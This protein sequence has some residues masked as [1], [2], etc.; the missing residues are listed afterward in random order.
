MLAA[1]CLSQ[2]LHSTGYATISFGC[3]LFNLKPKTTH[4]KNTYFR[5][6]V[7]S[8]DLNKCWT[9]SFFANEESK[10]K[11]TMQQILCE[12]SFFQWNLFC[13]VVLLKN[14]RMFPHL[15][16]CTHCHS[17][18]WKMELGNFPMF[19]SFYFSYNQKCVRT[20]HEF[21]RQ[22]SQLRSAHEFIQNTEFGLT[23]AR[24]P[25]IDYVIQN[26]ARFNKFN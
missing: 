16:R 2:H 13:C 18:K 7:V 24:F 10:K 14:V 4:R 12:T 11:T 17:T 20:T 15:T 5:R 19:T 6:V 1:R 25:R 3:A 9:F 21:Y 26:V 22:L 8:G 23:A